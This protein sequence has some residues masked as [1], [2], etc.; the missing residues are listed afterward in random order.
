MKIM[1]NF[2]YAIQVGSFN[3]M[4]KN[5]SKGT[6]TRQSSVLSRLFTKAYKKAIHVNGNTA[7]FTFYIKDSNGEYV[8]WAGSRYYT[9]KNA[10]NLILRNIRF[11]KY[12]GEVSVLEVNKHTL[13]IDTLQGVKVVQRNIF[14]KNVVNSI[15]EWVGK[16]EL[17]RL[18][19]NERM[20]NTDK[21]DNHCSVID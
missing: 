7:C 9:F 20:D 13:K 2:S 16:E 8:P 18:Q 4:D 21:Q 17:E 19:F 1:K 10:P 6:M 14:L 15:K 11:H 12:L 5:Q 3:K